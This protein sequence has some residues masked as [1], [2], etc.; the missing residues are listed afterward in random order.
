MSTQLTRVMEELKSNILEENEKTLRLDYDLRACQQQNHH[1][2]QKIRREAQLKQ[3]VSESE[4]YLIDKIDRLEKE[5]R[6]K[7]DLLKSYTVENL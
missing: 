3:D 2:L 7:D 1:L 6:E 4:L 5:L